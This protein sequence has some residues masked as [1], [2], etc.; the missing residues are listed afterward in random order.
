MAVGKMAAGETKEVEIAVEELKITIIFKKAI[1]QV[2]QMKIQ[3]HRVAVSGECGLKKK[4]TQSL[5]FA[6]M[7][8]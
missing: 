7:Q 3:R 2:F 4:G 8:E 5:Q 6:V 1:L